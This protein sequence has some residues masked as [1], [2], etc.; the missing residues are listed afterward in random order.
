[1]VLQAA[2]DASMKEETVNLS[3]TM[4]AKVES[5]K[6]ETETSQK[7]KIPARKRSCE[8]MGG[9]SGWMDDSDFK[10]E[11]K[12]KSKLDRAWNYMTP[13]REKDMWREISES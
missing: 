4:E 6:V 8:L 2:L 5:S 10:Y 12:D 7:C 11:P 3:F 1:M 9:G 13:R